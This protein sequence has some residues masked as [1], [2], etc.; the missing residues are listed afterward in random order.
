MGFDKEELSK[1]LES[2]RI[3]RYH[4][5]KKMSENEKLSGALMGTGPVGALMYAGTA[6]S[7]RCPRCNEKLE[8]NAKFCSECGLAL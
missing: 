1:R 3:A 7:E 6:Q 4:K 5:S 8:K 2:K